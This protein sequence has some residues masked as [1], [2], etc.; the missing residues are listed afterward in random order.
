MLTNH[1]L[2][3]SMDEPTD[4]IFMMPKLPVNPKNETEKLMGID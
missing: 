1:I 4:E 3:L 2:Y